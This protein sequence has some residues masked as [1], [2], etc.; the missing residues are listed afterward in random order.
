MKHRI[1]SPRIWVAL[2]CMTVLLGAVTWRLIVIGVVRHAW[3]AETA[4]TQADGVSNV[5]IRGNMY[6]TGLDGQRLLVA[7]NTRFPVLMA[8]PGS[9]DLAQLDASVAR[10]A[11]ITGADPEVIRRGLTATTSGARPVVRKLTEDQATRIRAAAIAGITIGSETD[12]SYPAGTLAADTI[13]FLGYGEH[14]REGQYGVESSYEQELS[15][16]AA[17]LITKRWDVVG[18]IKRL[19]GLAESE[20]RIDDRPR[21]VELT[22]DRNIQSYAEGVLEAVLTKYRAASGVLIVQ[23]PTTGRILALADRPTYNPNTYNSA[24]TVNFLNAAIT[25]FEPGSSFKPFTMAMGLNAN[26]VTPDTTFDDVENVVV[27]GYTIKNFNEGHFGRVTMTRVLEKSINSG[28]MWV[29]QKV[30]NEAFLNDAIALG[31]GQKTGIDL[32][33]EAPG[34][35][36]NLYS[37]RRINFLTA[38][39]G[40]GITVT[41]LQLIDG[42]SAIAN[43]GSLMRPYVVAA[44]HEAGADPVVTKPEVMGTPFSA[45]TAA[46][47]RTMLTS[48]VDNGFDKARIARYDV[49]GKTG[50]AQIASPEGGYL[51]GQY[52]HS[53]V[54]F[55]PASNPKFTILIKMEKPQGITF[56]AD[57]LSPSF[58]DMAL[59]LLNYYNIPPTR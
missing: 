32:P 13:G 51:E 7:T 9:I 40:Q 2:A 48:V 11:E 37:G 30:G 50:T 27:D 52:N 1:G 39:F 54:G 57:S 46:Q 58:R 36:N 16:K 47:L 18:R 38:S 12:R 53:F 17:S 59:Y 8:T 42:Y 25:P 49:A 24:A 5:L 44:V 21:D 55:A 19:L 41:P 3:Y 20:T 29:E 43:G 31:F 45:K 10:L 15:G 33:G 23:E 34:D 6:L 35:L 28:V 4:T 22:I 56:A 14:G 26:L